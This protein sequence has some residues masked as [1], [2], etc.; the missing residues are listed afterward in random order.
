M[1]LNA[2]TGWV[3]IIETNPATALHVLGSIIASYFTGA[4]TGHA[5]CSTRSYRFTPY[6]NEWHVSTDGKNRFHLV[7]IIEVILEMKTVTNLKLQ[8]MHL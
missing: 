2:S 8:V 5:D 4:F 7:V 3:G 6:A 1:F